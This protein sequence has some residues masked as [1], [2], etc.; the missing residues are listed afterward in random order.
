MKKSGQRGSPKT[1]LQKG[2]MTSAEEMERG[3]N[4]QKLVQ[5]CVRGLFLGWG[6]ERKNSLYQNKTARMAEGETGKY[7]KCFLFLSKSSFTLSPVKPPVETPAQEWFAFVLG[8]H[9]QFGR[10]C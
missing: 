2:E 5:K 9:L 7:S 10:V 3:E 8:K 6:G 1:Y 4:G